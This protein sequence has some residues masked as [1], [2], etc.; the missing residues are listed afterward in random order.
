[1]DKTG[2]GK[3]GTSTTGILTETIREMTMV[4]I[5]NG[6]TMIIDPMM[7]TVSSVIG[8]TRFRREVVQFHVGAIVVSIASKKAIAGIGIGPMHS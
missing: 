3:A 6:I 4:L 2:I 8:L 1:L 7:I 5:I